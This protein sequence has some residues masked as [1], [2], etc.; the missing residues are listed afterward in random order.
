MP[1]MEHLYWWSVSGIVGK[2]HKSSRELELFE[3][4]ITENKL[5][6]ENLTKLMVVILL[7]NLSKLCVVTGPK[8]KKDNLSTHCLVSRV[9]AAL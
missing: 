6:E 7:L 3:I 2:N 9:L 8:E 5:V 1:S 4:Q